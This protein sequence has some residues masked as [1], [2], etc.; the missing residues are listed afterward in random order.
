MDDEA[1]ACGR[2][3]ADEHYRFEKG[4]RMYGKDWKLI[5]DY[6]RTRTMTQVGFFGE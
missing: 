6:V 4:Y 3:N 1:S 2:W 5:A